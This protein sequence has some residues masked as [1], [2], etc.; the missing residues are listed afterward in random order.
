MA[1]TLTPLIL[2][3]LEWVDAGRRDQAAVMEAWRTSCPRLTVWED[4][5]DGGFVAR[6]RGEDGALLVEVT[7]EGRRFLAAAGRPA[8]G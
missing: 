7:P 6:R 1:D 2:D 4:A 3:F 8:A 5:V